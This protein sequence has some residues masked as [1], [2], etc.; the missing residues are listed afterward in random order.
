MRKIGWCGLP[1]QA[2]PG[3]MLGMEPITSPL[4]EDV[5]HVFSPSTDI[6]VAFFVEESASE[7]L[8]CLAVIPDEK[9]S[10]VLAWIHTFSA[11]TFPL[12]QY[13]RVLTHS[14]WRRL[15]GRAAQHASLSE[16]Y[17]WASIVAGEMLGQAD[18]AAS[19][20]AVPLGWAH[21]CLSYSMARSILG[22]EWEG[23]HPAATV[24]ERLIRWEADPIFQGKRVGAREMLSIWQYVEDTYRTSGEAVGLVHAIVEKVSSEVA[25][26]LKSN[27][28]I[29]SSSAEQRVQGF[30]QIVDQVISLP[31]SKRKN[32]GLLL[33]SAT[34][35]VGNGT[36]HLDLLQPYS[37]DFPDAYIWFGLLAGFGG[38]LVWDPSWLRLAKG[39]DRILAANYEVTDALQADLSW[40]EY[41]WLSSSFREIEEFLAL[42]KQTARSLTVELL[43]GV[44]CQFRLGGSKGAARVE[45]ASPHEL[46]AAAVGAVETASRP[47][48]EE[49]VNRALRLLAEAQEVL[50]AP[51][52]RGGGVQSQLF[53]A[54]TAPSTDRKKVPVKKATSR[55]ASRKTAG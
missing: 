18:A 29:T 24:V 38:P 43:P 3:V 15:E 39:V 16:R 12:S 9:V 10:E 50:S 4:R 40:V 44:T 46:S 21:G 45:G 53:S 17:R 27:P 7:R 23:P 33:A 13:C 26:S 36:S 5:D 42:P 14:E 28:L 34:F 55:G 51:D 31:A 1:R 37:R 54:A 6:A 41:E 20:A 48:I 35:M 19:V 52:N 30:D 32:A 49:R 25:Y 22:F 2:I 47:L 8:P 11:E